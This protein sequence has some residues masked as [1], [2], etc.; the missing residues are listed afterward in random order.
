MIHC[1]NKTTLTTEKLLDEMH[2]QWRLAGGKSKE[3]K[4]F[5][6]EDK[7]ALAAMNT[8]KEGK[9][10][11]GGGK[12]TKENN[13]KNKICNHCNNKGHIKNTCWEKYPEKKPKFSK[14]CKSKQ[15]GREF[16]CNSCD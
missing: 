11:N 6:N 5:N 14:N 9:D 8:K 2:I 16:S 12:P 3:D 7:I 13:N 15:A 1:K 10:P 4:D